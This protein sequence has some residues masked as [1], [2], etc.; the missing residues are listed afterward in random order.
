M[1]VVAQAQVERALAV[2]IGAQ[3]QSEPYVVRA[4][5]V[6]AQLDHQR[7]VGAAAD[8]LQPIVHLLIVAGGRE[9]LQV[10]LDLRQVDALIGSALH[11]PRQALGARGVHALEA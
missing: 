7:L 2:E 11:Q 10:A 9:L 3:V 8:A 4:P 6:L 5:A 1:A